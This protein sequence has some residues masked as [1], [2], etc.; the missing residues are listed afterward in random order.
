MQSPQPT[1]RPG[2]LRMCAMRVPAWWG[3]SSTELAEETS[4]GGGLGVRGGE[5]GGQ[6]RGEEGEGRTEGRGD[7]SDGGG[8]WRKKPGQETGKTGQPRGPGAG[9]GGPGLV[10]APSLSG[11]WRSPRRAEVPARSTCF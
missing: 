11:R 4:L 3:R 10:R 9:L 7:A 2:S 6:G 5:S 1:G 8:G